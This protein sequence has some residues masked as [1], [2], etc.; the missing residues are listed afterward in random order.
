[1]YIFSNYEKHIGKKGKGEKLQTSQLLRMNARQIV[2][3]YV[4][5][6]RPKWLVTANRLDR[7]SV[8]HMDQ[9]HDTC[10]SWIVH[11]LD[12]GTALERRHN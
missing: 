3:R 12:S 2:R 4:V 5:F 1:M 6:P 11:Q 8:S 7:R 9:Y 10:Y